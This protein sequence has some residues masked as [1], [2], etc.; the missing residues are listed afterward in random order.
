MAA[1]AILVIALSGCAAVP[2]AQTNNP[3]IAAADNGALVV[4]LEEN[5]SKNSVSVTANGTV[6]VTPDVAYTTVGVVTQK[7]KMQDAQTANRDLMNTVVAALKE[8]GLT[9]DDIRTTNY[10]VYPVYDYSGDTSKIASFEVNNTVELTIRDINKVGEILDAAA[11]AGANTSYSVRFDVLDKEPS[12]NQA[13]TAAMESARAKADTLAAAGKFT[14]KAVMN[15][16][17]GYTSSSIYREYAAME[18]PAADQ[19]T[20]VNAGDLDVTATVTVV[21]EIE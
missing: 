18:A 10:S 13:L 14:I 15:V 21:F 2:A 5:P 6:K 1:S 12:Y 19:A 7:K 16:S 20:Y 3:S 17:E 8:A 9:D 11:A 4:Q